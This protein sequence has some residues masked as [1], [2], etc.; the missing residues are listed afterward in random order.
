MSKVLKELLD[1]FNECRLYSGTVTSISLISLEAR[2]SVER[3]GRKS[4]PVTDL[5]R[6]QLK[7]KCLRRVLR[8][9]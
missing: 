5:N 4:R 9:N 2:L 7:S 6:L 1:N 8:A 3:D